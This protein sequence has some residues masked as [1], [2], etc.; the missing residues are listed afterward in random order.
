MTS[1]RLVILSFMLATVAVAQDSQDPEA[2]AE[3]PTAEQSADEDAEEVLLDD[4]FVP[5]KEIPADQEVAFPVD[6]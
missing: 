1:W 4:D 5:T 3:E 6:I 2:A